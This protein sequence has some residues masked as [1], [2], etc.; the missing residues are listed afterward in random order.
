MQSVILL[1]PFKYI[2]F[3]I[4]IASFSTSND[5]PQGPGLSFSPWLSYQ[6]GAKQAESYWL[7]GSSSN[8]C[9]PMWCR[10][11]CKDI[12]T[13]IDV[14]KDGHL[15]FLTPLH[16]PAYFSHWVICVPLSLGRLWPINYCKSNVL[17]TL[18][19]KHRRNES[20]YHSLLGTLTYRRSPQNA[21]TMW[22]VQ[23]GHV[24]RLQGTNWGSHSPHQHPVMGMSLPGHSNPV[25]SPDDYRAKQIH[26]K[27]KN[28]S[29]EY[30]RPAELW[31][32]V[33]GCFKVTGFCTVSSNREMKY[34]PLG[35]G[36]QCR[37]YKNVAQVPTMCLLLSYVFSQLILKRW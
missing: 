37:E 13:V 4:L 24:E 16:A 36:R 26:V 32:I 12:Q 10:E 8:T 9:T 22:E 17:R 34:R 14:S 1:T 5:S 11:A 28:H 21:N 7:V 15:P 3:W 6:M 2:P 25:Q 19:A 18:K 20:F 33:T 23:P 35:K 29:P 31:E 27:W 30:S